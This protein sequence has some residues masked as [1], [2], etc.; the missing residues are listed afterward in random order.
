MWVEPIH[1]TDGYYNL[2]QEPGLGLRIEQRY[3]DQH[4]IG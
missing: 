2:P 1:V 4:R 3:L